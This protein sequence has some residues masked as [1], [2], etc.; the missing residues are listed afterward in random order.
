MSTDNEI[1]FSSADYSGTWNQI[2]FVTLGEFIYLI[3]G[4]NPLGQ[5]LHDL[6]ILPH[7]MMGYEEH[8]LDFNL[9]KIEKFKSSWKAI[10]R[11]GC[12]L[13]KKSTAQIDVQYL[14]DDL[15]HY[16]ATFLI[17]WAKAKNIKINSLYQPPLSE[18]EKDSTFDLQENP[19]H[20][21]RMNSIYK[22]LL[23]M[24][25]SKYGY[26]PNKERNTSTGGNR[27]SIRLDVQLLGKNINRDDL[28]LDIKEDTVKDI[29]DAAVEAILK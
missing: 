24:A 1:F 9:D 3:H 18:E 6:V 10:T 5:R 17:E 21:K 28:R 7:H 29:L 26:V 13:P 2:E 4:F 27:G 25:V 11:L 19:V 15:P 14:R 8:Y 12:E 22:L 20:P 23:A 16:K